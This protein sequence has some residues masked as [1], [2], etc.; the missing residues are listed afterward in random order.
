METLSSL[1]CLWEHTTG[2]YPKSDGANQH[3]TKESTKENIYL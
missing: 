3:H 1:S 2:P